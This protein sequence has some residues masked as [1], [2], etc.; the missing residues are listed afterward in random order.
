MAERSEAKSAKLRA[1]SKYLE[2]LFFTRS[3]AS[4]LFGRFI[5]AKNGLVSAIFSEIQV[6]NKLVT[7]LAR[8]NL[9]DGLIIV[10]RQISGRQVK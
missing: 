2:F 8:V 9:R 3:F 10:F 1:A 6:D 5:C 7:L 4:R